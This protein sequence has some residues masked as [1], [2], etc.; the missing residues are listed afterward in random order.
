MYIY[1]VKPSPYWLHLPEIKLVQKGIFLL[2]ALPLL[3]RGVGLHS[4]YLQTEAK[5]QV[6]KSFW[7][8]FSL[9]LY[10]NGI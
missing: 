3:P 9:Q 8:Y 5:S 7:Y 6:T 10:A 2:Q 1:E 4:V